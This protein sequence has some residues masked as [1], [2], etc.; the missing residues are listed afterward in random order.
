MDNL[1]GFRNLLF[2]FILTINRFPHFSA[3]PYF[4][5]KHIAMT[6]VVLKSTSKE[7]IL[8]L[9]QLAHKL[10]VDV[11]IVKEKD[12]EDLAMVHAIESGKTGKQISVEELLLRFE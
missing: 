8:L 5:S 2:E 3:F 4:W 11:S 1:R 12:L 10:G 6:S 9:V 7:N